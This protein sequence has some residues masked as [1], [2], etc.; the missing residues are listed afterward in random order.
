MILSEKEIKEFKKIKKFLKFEKYKILLSVT[1]IFVSIILNIF[2]G[3]LALTFSILALLLLI[4][5]YF[6]QKSKELVTMYE[7]VL[8]SESQ[9][10][11]LNSEI[12]E[13]K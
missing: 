11:H 13:R 8:A 5:I 3:K 4:E 2:T 10:I 9:N 6:S 12:L 7:K 1:M